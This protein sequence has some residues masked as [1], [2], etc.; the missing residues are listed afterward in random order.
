MLDGALVTGPALGA[1]EFLGSA[2]RHRLAAALRLPAFRCV[3]APRATERLYEAARS[4]LT[5][6]RENAALGK[7]SNL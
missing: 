3:L 2:R 6:T 7:S 4:A 5:G 1:V